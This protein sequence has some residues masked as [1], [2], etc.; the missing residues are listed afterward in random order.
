MRTILAA[1]FTAVEHRSIDLLVIHDMEYPERKTA[2]ED[3]AA[4]FHNQPKG[5]NGTS[6]HYCIDEDSVVR[7]VRDHDIAWAAPGANS[8]G[9]HFELAGYSKQNRG[10]WLDEYGK[11]LLHNAAQIVAHKAVRYR[12]PVSHHLSADEVRRGHRG[13]CGHIDITHAWPTMGTHTDPGTS[14]PWHYFMD[15]VREFKHQYSR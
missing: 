8:D 13:I 14:F 12:I 11:H 4:F 9:L 2:A 3:V 10:D 7:S 15:L 5:S 6:A 1:N